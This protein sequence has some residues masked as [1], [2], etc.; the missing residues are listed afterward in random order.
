VEIGGWHKELESYNAH[1][2][3]IAGLV[4]TVTCL[5]AVILSAQSRSERLLVRIKKMRRSP[6]SI[7]HP[8]RCSAKCRWDRGRTSSSHPAD[9]KIAFAS[10]YARPAPGH[11]I[12]D[13]RHRVAEGVTPASTSRRSAVRTASRSRTASSI[14][15]LKPIRKSPATIRPP[16]RSTGSSRPGKRPTHMVLP[17]RDAKT[18]SR[19]TSDPTACR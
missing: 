4:W 10:N 15:R 1:M 13:D 14:S 3:K 6:S 9:G 12:S 8:V 18:S 7:R 2:K 19:R 17:T 5:A 16:T 11:T